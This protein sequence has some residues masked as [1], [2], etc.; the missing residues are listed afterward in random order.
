[1]ILEESY[2]LALKNWLN[3]PK[4]ERNLKKSIF[5]RRLKCPFS[6]KFNFFLPEA[7]YLIDLYMPY[8]SRRKLESVFNS[9][10]QDQQKHSV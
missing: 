6:A 1:M 4:M 7:N 9:A 10:Q 5:Y 2:F 8:F 3:T